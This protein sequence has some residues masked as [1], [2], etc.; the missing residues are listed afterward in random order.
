MFRMMDIYRFFENPPSIILATRSRE[1]YRDQRLLIQPEIVPLPSK[2]LETRGLANLLAAILSSIGYLAFS[3]ILYMRLRPK[4]SYIK[5]VHA[6]YIFPQGLFGLILAYLLK[7]PLIVSAVGQDVNEMMRGIIVSQAENERIRTNVVFKGICRFVL[8]RATNTVAVSRP[9]E[10]TLQQFHTHNCVFIPSSVDTT[11]LCPRDEASSP[12][13]ILSVAAMIDRKR[14]LLLLNAFEKVVMKIQEATLVMVGNGP[15]LGVVKEEIRR[16]GLQD[17]VKL[18][19]H[20]NWPSHLL[21]ELLFGASV[22]VL[23]SLCEGLSYALLE[24]MACGK[25][26]V[27]SSNE[28]HKEIFQ[29]GNNALLFCLD[30]EKDLAEKL[31]LAL[32]SNRLRTRLSRSVRELCIS[33]FSN[34]EAG[35]KLEKVYLKA[36]RG[37]G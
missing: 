6:H 18:F 16:K 20:L 14:P 36:I 5:L 26:I 19:P 35:P 12:H 34:N 9:L 21:E 3:L 33:Q 7:V 32:T 37:R 11:S 22:F 27:A 28:S 13:S 24:A 23:P 25:V 8:K 29:D 2:G 31:V 15:L 17:R 10:T 30:D 1:F 4:K